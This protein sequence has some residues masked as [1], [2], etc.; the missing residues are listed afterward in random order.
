M[1]SVVVS[2]TWGI[3]VAGDTISKPGLA[4][5]GLML[6]VGGIAGIA[7]NGQLASRRSET[8]RML[9]ILL[10]CNSCVA[11]FKLALTLTS[12]RGCGGRPGDWRAGCHRACAAG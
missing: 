11:S 7:L 5:P 3:K 4:A 2:F 10:A 1:P 8:Q 12:H 6:L 9:C